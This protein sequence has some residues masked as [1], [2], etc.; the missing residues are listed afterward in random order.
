MAEWDAVKYEQELAYGLAL[1]GEG[2]SYFAG[3]RAEFVKERVSRSGREVTSI[4]E[5]GCGLG[6]NLIALASVFPS[7]RLLGLDASAAMLQRAR[8]L[9]VD[10][11]IELRD[12][13]AFRDEACCDL[14]FVNGVMHHVPPEQRPGVMDRLWSL[15]RPGGLLSLFDN[16]PLNPGAMWV[17]SRI[18]FDRDAK[19]VTA[20]TLARLAQR[21]GFRATEI[22]THFYF[23][24]ALRALRAAEPLLARLPLGAQYGLYARR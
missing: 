20:W 14:V 23:P 17:M 15:L 21:A 11:R 6:L 13:R 2:A 10:P 1:A 16:N 19:P 18:P 8:E 7:A 5:F 24:N 12:S 3:R 4:C 22:R 9:C